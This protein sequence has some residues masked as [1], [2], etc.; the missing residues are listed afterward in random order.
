MVDLQQQ[1][2]WLRHY[3]LPGV[4]QVLRRLG[5]RLHR[6]RLRLHSP[7][8]AYAEKVFQLEL[9]RHLARR[10]PERV[11]FVYTDEVHL[12][13]QPTLAGC[14][15][16][17]GVEPTAPLACRPNDVVRYT[18]ALDAVTGRLTWQSADHWTV[19]ALCGFLRTLRAAYPKRLLALAWDNWG[20]HRHP[21]VQATAAKLHIQLVWLPTYAPWTNPIEKL[22]RWLRQSVVHHHRLAEQ[23]TALQQATTTFFNQFTTGSRELLRYVGLLPD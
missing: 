7:D 19:A 8:P 4:W 1:L 13:R 10:H 9:L 14:W 18:G 23:W 5:I 17:V 3:S 11:T 12:Q 6:G 21:T 15:A 2:A 22:W 20:N 16:P